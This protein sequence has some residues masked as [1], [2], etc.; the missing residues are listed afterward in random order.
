M[1]LHLGGHLRWYAP[2]RTGRLEL[3]LEEG[4]PLPAV[5]EMVGVPRAE[6]AVA[7]VNRRPV[8]LDE[9]IV[10]DADRVDLYPPVGG[11]CA[12]PPNGPNKLP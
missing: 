6:V 12:R 5:L 4:T 7:L 9:T 2:Q 10:T 3:R 8:R 1:H 11:G